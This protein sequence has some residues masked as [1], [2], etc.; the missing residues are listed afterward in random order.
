MRLGPHHAPAPD[1]LTPQLTTHCLTA[2]MRTARVVPQTATGGDPQP[3]V[4]CDLI[5]QVPLE[6]TEKLS[7]PLPADGP[8]MSVC[9]V[10]G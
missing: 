1:G 5:V 8:L 10:R 3:L 9:A 6:L 4:D 7:K 2:G